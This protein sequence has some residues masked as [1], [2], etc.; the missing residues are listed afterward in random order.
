MKPGHKLP[1]LD[2]AGATP[3]LAPPLKSGCTDRHRNC[4]RTRIKLRTQPPPVQPM[5]HMSESGSISPAILAQV[6]RRKEPINACLEVLK[7]VQPVQQLHGL[8]AS[9]YPPPISVP[10][11]LFFKATQRGTNYN[12][13]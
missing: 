3:P 5:I 4:W 1:K 13:E 9:F 11:P 10:V 2:G 8:K 7:T 6:Y 12:V